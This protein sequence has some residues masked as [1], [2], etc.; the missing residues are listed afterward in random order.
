MPDTLIGLGEVLWDCFPDRRRPGGAPANVAF[1][2]NQL[3]LQGVVCS[4][5]GTDALGDELNAH[6]VEHGLST[7]LI[8]R[9][10]THPTSTVD[11]R[12]DGDGPAYTIHEDVAW[13][14]LAYSPQLESGVRNC[15]ALAFGTLAQRSPTTRATIQQALTAAEG[16]WRIYDVN[17][18]PPFVQR[19]WLRASLARCEVVKLNHEELPTLAEVVARD[20]RDVVD[21]AAA[22]RDAFGVRLVCMTRGAA[23]CVLV[24]ADETVHCVGTPV[25]VADTVGAGDA[26]TAGL[27]AALVWAW[28]LEIAGRFA[29]AV[30]GL[31]AS[32]PGAMP[33]LDEEFAALR[34]QFARG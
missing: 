3:G 22:L 15:A 30:G 28:P 25:A 18:R 21:C 16:A 2:A 6:L 5:I 11:V 27:A 29:N 1:H 10:P 17:L 19:D 9:D 13:D 20:G 26:F 4:R 23:G 14:Y 7:A 31:V 34:A 8:Q 33:T 24:S 32:R 12:L